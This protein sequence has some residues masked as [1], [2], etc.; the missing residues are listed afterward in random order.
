MFF[1]LMLYRFQFFSSPALVSVRRR[2][3]MDDLIEGSDSRATSVKRS[4]D[5]LY[6]VSVLGREFYDR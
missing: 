5:L 4:R 3:F 1:V 6:V 2:M